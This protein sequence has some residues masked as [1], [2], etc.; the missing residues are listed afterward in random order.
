M[1]ECKILPP[2]GQMFNCSFA[3]SPKLASEL[4]WSPQTKHG[5]LVYFFI[6]LFEVF[7][8]QIKSIGRQS[9]L[10]TPVKYL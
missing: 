3:P 8:L 6:G 4:Q 5:P 1:R 10:S 2:R 7:P 9:G